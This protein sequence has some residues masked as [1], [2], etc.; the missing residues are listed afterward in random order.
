MTIG[1]M[2]CL[3][4]GC[5]CVFLTCVVFA[6]SKDAYD[7][8]NIPSEIKT[9][10]CMENFA[11]TAF[12]EVTKKAERKGRKDLTV[13]LRTSRIRNVVRMEEGN[14]LI[15][16]EYKKSMFGSTVPYGFETVESY[17]EVIQR[18]YEKEKSA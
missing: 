16:T 7:R 2:A 14:A 11:R 10:P 12:I 8:R 1:E 15:T 9:D 5:I 6:V 4:L 17:E 3:A 13:T 18:L